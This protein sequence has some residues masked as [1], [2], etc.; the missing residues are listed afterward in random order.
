MSEDEIRRANTQSTFDS[1]YSGAY[2]AQF[3]IIGLIAWYY[4]DGGYITF[5]PN[6]WSS[7]MVGIITVIL[8]MVL[9]VIPIVSNIFLTLLTFSWG[10]IAFLT[11]SETFDTS[12]G[13]SW[14]IAT[15]VT[16]SAGG[17]NMSGMQWSKD[18]N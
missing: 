5:I 18:I 11:C 16:L 4:Q 10:Y 15:L 2:I 9:S 14:A 7:V 3:V 12:S 13:T 17:L 8:C 1:E 6:D